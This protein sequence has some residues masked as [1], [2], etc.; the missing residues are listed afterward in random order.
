LYTLEGH[1]LE[2]DS[3]DFSP[4]GKQLASGSKDTTIRLYDTRTWTLLQTLTGNRGRIESL[5][6]SPDGKILVHGGG[7]GDTSITLWDL[8]KI[9]TA[10]GPGQGHED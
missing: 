1:V 4:D 3:V 9:R 6:F 7:G 5:E 8:K 2:T 10:K